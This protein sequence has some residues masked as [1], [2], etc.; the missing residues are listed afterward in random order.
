[1]E[2]LDVLA[3]NLAN[4]ATSGFKNDRE[5]YNLYMSS[6]GTSPVPDG[7]QLTVPVIE[8]QWTDFAQGVLQP[9]GNQLDLAISGPGFF[10]VNGPSGPLYTRNGSFKVSSEGQLVTVEGY[11][12][13]SA[14]GSEIKLSADKPIV[15]T[16][17]GTVRQE[18]A[19][20]GRIGAFDF[21]STAG[22]RKMGATYFQNG[23]TAAA[24]AAEKAEV[25]QGKLE[26]SN[27]PVA[28]AAMRLVGTMRQFEMLQ[29]AIGISSE[30]NRRSIEEVA[31]V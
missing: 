23:D 25:Q 12:V 30:M 28:E 24:T 11:A 31:K 7:P 26:N 9:T 21:K 22:L 1:M 13:R 3:N 14:D 6:E 15:I 2:A 20:V 4:A 18:G 27:V 17:D 5:F 10:A 19:I 29:K 8:K 16:T